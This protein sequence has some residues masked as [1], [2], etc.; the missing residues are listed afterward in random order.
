MSYGYR[1]Q[2]FNLTPYPVNL[3]ASLVNPDNWESA[4]DYNPL[5]FN[6]VGLLAAHSATI[7]HHEEIANDQ[8]VAEFYLEFSIVGQ[9][10]VSTLVDAE[11]VVRSGTGQG[12]RKGYLSTFQ[13]GTTGRFRVLEAQYDAIGDDS[14]RNLAVVLMP[15]IDT[16]NWMSKLRDEV[17][18]RDLTLPGSH[19][20]GANANIIEGSRCQDLSIAE[21][22]AAGVRFLDIRLDPTYP[23]QI[24]HGA[25]KTKKYYRNDCAVPIAEFLKHKGPDE[26]ILLCVG[27]DSGAYF[28][29][30][31]IQ[32]LES[33]LNGYF[34]PNGVRDHLFTDAVPGNLASLRGKVVLLRRYQID[35]ESWRAGFTQPMVQL[36]E[37][38]SENGAAH[39]GWPNNSD[40]FAETDGSGVFYQ[41]NTL[42]A[43][44]IQD[45]YSLPMTKWK[46]KVALIERYMDT[47]SQFYSGT[48]FINFLSCTYD[49]VTATP[50]AFAEGFN[51]IDAAVYVH[52]IRSGIGRYGTLPTDFMSQPEGLMEL[53]INSNQKWLKP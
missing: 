8:N 37:F 3:K 30:A 51:G 48:W 23:L 42:E 46:Q 22:L 29:Q 53:M 50:R 14:Y 25:S 19:D 24:I 27:Q 34:G 26:T 45:Y 5:Y 16:L 32:I 7:A 20:S 9:G 18:L 44:A 15:Q 2:I 35:D 13:D 28:H 47:A 40:T 1:L 39:Y 21:Q 10:A 6:T 43:F 33:T 38:Q 52:L 12:Y 4:T 49:I 41:T 11:A 31:V 36:L 17:L